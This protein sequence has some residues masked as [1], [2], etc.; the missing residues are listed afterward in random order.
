MRYRTI[1]EPRYTEQ[2]AALKRIAQKL[3]LVYFLPDYHGSKN[4]KNTVFFYT[5]EAHNHN[6]A[7]DRQHKLGL[8][9]VDE[10]KDYDAWFENTDANGHASYDFA[11]FG[12]IDLRGIYW[13]QRLATY[14]AMSHVFKHR[15]TGIPAETTDFIDAW[16][17]YE[18]KRIEIFKKVHGQAF[19]GK[20]NIDDKEKRAAIAAGETD[21]LEKLEDQPTP[22]FFCDFLVPKYDAELATYLRQW[23]DPEAE[24]SYFDLIKKILDRIDYLGGIIVDWK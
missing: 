21:P 9:W 5:K 20:Y 12:D 2:Q 4:D 19:F 11:R 8:A 22:N 13:E 1:E 17:S 18:L 10:Y 14:I 16:N 6:M 23:S 7:V 3:D 15:P 24:K